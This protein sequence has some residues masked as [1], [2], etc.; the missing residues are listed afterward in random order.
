MQKAAAEVVACLKDYRQFLEKEVLPRANGQWR[1]GPEKF[2]KKLDLE[3]DAGLMADEVLAAAEADFVRVQRELYLIAR[4]LWGRCY[5]LAA[6]P[7]DDAAG[8]RAT[9]RLVIEAVEKEH[10][11]PED[12]ARDART[13]VQRI[14][15]FIRD[16]KILRLPEPDRCQVIEMPE[17]KRGNST[18]YMDAA[19]P[20]DATA[21]S[22]T[23]SA[24]RRRTGTPPACGA[25]WRNTTGTCSRC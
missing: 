4:Q 21:E 12:L 9:V 14:R 3:L 17:F 11:R 13:T 20:L 1:L 5:P 19:P 16:H 18:A 2:A 6:L 24:R 10:G 23:P 8:H 22:S 7:P 25:C 15:R